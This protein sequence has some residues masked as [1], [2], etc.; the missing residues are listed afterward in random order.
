MGARIIDNIEYLKLVTSP[1][2]V[3]IIRLMFRFLLQPLS[4]EKAAK[5]FTRSSNK[6]LNK[7]I[8]KEARLPG[9]SVTADRLELLETQDYKIAYQI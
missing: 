4:R 9:S 6:S 1:N 3:K 5:C 8:G 7:E 2:A